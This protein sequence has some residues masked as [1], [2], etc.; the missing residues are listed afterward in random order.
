MVSGNTFSSIPSTLGG[1]PPQ[2]QKQSTNPNPK[3]NP[4]PASRKKRNLPGTPGKYI[5][6]KAFFYSFEFS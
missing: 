2:G 6:F 5:K 4:N 1:L 3:P